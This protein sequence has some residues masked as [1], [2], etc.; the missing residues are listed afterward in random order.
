MSGKRKITLLTILVIA[1]VMAACANSPEAIKDQIYTEAVKTLCAEFTET[2]KAIPPT[3]TATALPTN[4]AEP[5]ATQTPIMIPTVPS[6]G[7]NATPTSGVV[8][9]YQVEFVWVDPYPNQFVPNQKFTMTWQL[10][11]IGTATWSGKYRFY[12]RNGIQLA[13]QSSYSINEIISPGGILTISMPATAPEAFG[14]YQTEWALANPE[15][16]EFYYV[17]YTA[18]VGEQ[19][20]ITSQ[21]S[22]ATATPNSLYWMCSDAERSNIQGNGCDEF[23]RLNGS[24]LAL[25]G[26]KCYSYGEQVTTY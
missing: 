20:F 9:P 22:E 26:L 5:T 10:K 3:E 18:N 4:T 6:A 25:N 7:M 16:V 23:C 14:T 8:N 15:G 24:N 13:D 21:P 19:S 12:H 1:A 17:Y 2:A 11:N